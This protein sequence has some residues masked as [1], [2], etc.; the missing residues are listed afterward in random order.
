MPGHAHARNAGVGLSPRPRK[1]LH[2]PSGS[3]LHRGKARD[4]R[5]RHVQTTL[6]CLLQAPLS[7]PASTGW[8]EVPVT[9]DT[10][11]PGPGLPPAVTSIAFWSRPCML[12]QSACQDRHAHPILLV[13][14]C[15]KWQTLAS[16]AKTGRARP[17]PLNEVDSPWILRFQQGAAICYDRTQAEAAMT[18]SAAPGRPLSSAGWLLWGAFKQTAR[19]SRRICNRGKSFVNATLP[20]RRTLVPPI[21]AGLARKYLLSATSMPGKDHARILFRLD[22][23]EGEGRAESS[24]GAESIAPC[25]QPQSE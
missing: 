12:R 7:L 2:P 17:V 20:P 15:T 10:R 8:V 4:R 9:I 22:A 21:F 14:V 6:Q 3:P 18:L 5:S 11:A 1:L 24:I 13:G 23:W 25:D 19:K 16:V